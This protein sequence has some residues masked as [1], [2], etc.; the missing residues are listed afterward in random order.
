MIDAIA[1]ISTTL[2]V[3]YVVL[4]AYLLDRKLPW[5]ETEPS[6]PDR[7]RAAAPGQSAGQSSDSRRV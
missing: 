5:F 3:L 4:R 6:D 2:V 1:I 7:G